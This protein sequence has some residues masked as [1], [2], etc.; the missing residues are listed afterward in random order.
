VQPTDCK[1]KPRWEKDVSRQ[2]FKKVPADV[3]FN[4]FFLTQKDEMEITGRNVIDW[5]LIIT[6]VLLNIS[7]LPYSSDSTQSIPSSERIHFPD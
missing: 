1:Q 4:L 6:A 5:H 2:F 3:F 7:Q